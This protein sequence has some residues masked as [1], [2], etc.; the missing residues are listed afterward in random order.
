MQKTAE[1]PRMFV[2]IIEPWERLRGK[3]A[4]LAILSRA[5]EDGQFMARLAENPAEALSGYYSL[6]P[7]ELAALVSGDM[8]K[9]E[10]WLGKLDKKQATWLWA[11]LGQ[12]K[13]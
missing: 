10:G 6:N 3:E 13:W 4:I 7:E 2:P 9:I 5:A 11:R 1:K 8:R 12:E